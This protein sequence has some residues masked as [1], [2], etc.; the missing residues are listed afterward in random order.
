M[1]PEVVAR[2]TT[3]S[4]I[5]VRGAIDTVTPCPDPDEPEIIFGRVAGESPPA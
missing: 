4:S 2:R 3:V 5:G 1:I